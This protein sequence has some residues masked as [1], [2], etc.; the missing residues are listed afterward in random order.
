METKLPAIFDGEVV[1][2]VG[3]GVSLS[4]FDFS[5]LQKPVIAIN[6]S[7]IQCDCHVVVAIDPPWEKK[8]MKELDAFDGLKISYNGRNMHSF[9]EV[10][11]EPSPEPFSEDWCIL[12]S[13]LSGFFALSLAFHLGASRVIL[14]GFDGGYE[15][16]RPTYYDNP[17]EGVTRSSY[18]N[19][20]EHYDVFKLPY[21]NRILNVGLD[22]KIESFPK[23]DIDSDFYSRFPS[24]KQDI[25]KINI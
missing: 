8:F 5:R 21:W 25:N 11:I 20:N 17:S 1:T 22:S 24:K 12:K 10:F 2:I 13:N 19:A 4:G 7:F 14:L 15:G 3:G 16:E 18:E 23:M 9:H 6:S